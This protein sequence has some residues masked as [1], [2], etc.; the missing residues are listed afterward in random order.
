MIVKQDGVECNVLP[1]CARRNDGRNCDRDCGKCDLLRDAS[2]ILE[3]YQITISGLKELQ[4]YR[5]IGTVEECSAAMEKQTPINHHHTRINK[6]PV[7]TRDTVCPSC[8]GVTRTALNE[9]PK[10][11]S[12]CGQA[13]KWG[14]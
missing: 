1:D 14:D 10:Y 6:E 13:L 4:K 11:C 5:Q 9:F 2:E 7:E 12:I 3:A 8:L